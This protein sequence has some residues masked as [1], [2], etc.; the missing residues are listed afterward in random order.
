MEKS[1]LKLEAALETLNVHA[2]EGRLDADLAHAYANCHDKKRGGDKTPQRLAKKTYYNWLSKAKSGGLAPSKR[3]KELSMPEW[4]G[5]LLQH[6]RLPQKPTLT[7]AMSA[8]LPIWTGAG[9]E[10]FSYDQAY[11]LLKNLETYA[12]EILYRGR[13]QGA[14]M[15][16]LLPFVRR[17]TEHLWSNDVWTGDGHG[18]KAKVQHPDHGRPFTPEVTLIMDVASRKVLGWSVSF[19]ENMIA[20]CDALRHAVTNHGLPLIYYSDNGSGQTGKMLDA[21]IGGMLARLGIDHQTGIPGNPQGRGMIERLWGTLTIPLAKQLPTYRGNGADGDYLRKTT[22]QI[23]KDL[24]A[25][26]K[27]DA[28]PTLPE[29]VAALDTAIA[30]Y[31]S[32]HVHSALSATPDQAYAAK[33]READR[34]MLDEHE[35]LHLF[36]PHVE[37]VAAR[38]EVS[39]WHNIYFSPELMAVDRQKVLV[40]YD[41]H[42]PEFV[43]VRRLDG[44]FICRADWNANARKYFP[45]SKTDNLREQRVERRIKKLDGEI[46]LALAES[47]RGGHVIEVELKPAEVE[48]ERGILSGFAP[49]VAEQSKPDQE[50]IS[51]DALLAMYAKSAAPEPQPFSEDALLALYAK[52][53]PKP[54]RAVFR[55][56]QP[57]EDVAMYLVSLG[58]K[59]NPKNE[60]AAR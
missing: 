26:R 8:A 43:V 46:D 12:P 47:K 52:P 41:I 59:P 36:R 60:E 37:R 30:W 29:F 44:E 16:A 58:E 7:Q 20:V 34:T 14:A 9:F 56:M 42:D 54:E 32:E 35:K 57:G 45:E 40:G 19:A 39:L 22:T 2:G 49:I 4:G 53:E 11:R 24:R 10:P 28:L 18:M 13:N 23:E 55:P 15:K 48:S 27:P 25:G 17:D 1:G 21:P 51:G 5:L 31:N 38:G 50:M 3:K 6:Y 33:L